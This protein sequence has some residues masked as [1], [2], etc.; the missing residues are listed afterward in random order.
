MS[1]G[2]FTYLKKAISRYQQYS[3]QRL[4]QAQHQ[5]PNALKHWSEQ[6]KDRVLSH[7]HSHL[8]NFAYQTLSVLE[9]VSEDIIETA[10][11]T[12]D[13]VCDAAQQLIISAEQKL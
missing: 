7:H 10:R 1:K 8:G 2:D 11:L 12:N 3:D 6:L 13:Y 4:R 9:P 5:L